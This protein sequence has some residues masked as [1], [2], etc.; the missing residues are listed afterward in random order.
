[1]TSTAKEHTAP[2]TTYPWLPRFVE[3][4]EIL[5]H[6]I[7]FITYWLNIMLAITFN[8]Q[9]QKL[10]LEGNKLSSSFLRVWV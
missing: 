7:L 3:A 10:N 4:F 5:K 2:C 8:R 6:K 1:M 9:L